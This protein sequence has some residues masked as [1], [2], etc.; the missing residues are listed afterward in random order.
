MLSHVHSYIRLGAGRIGAGRIGAGD[1]CRM[2]IVIQVGDVIEAMDI[3]V[4]ERK[5]ESAENGR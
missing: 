5:A 4:N 3:F 2:T 1:G